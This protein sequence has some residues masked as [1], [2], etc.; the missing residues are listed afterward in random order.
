MTT[1]AGTDL[2]SGFL[3]K[4]VKL[5]PKITGVAMSFCTAFGILL[6]TVSIGVSQY[7]F[8]KTMF[9]TALITVCYAIIAI[10]LFIALK[11]RYRIPLQD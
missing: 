9:P 2:M 5:Y 7:F 6:N 10:A 8:D 11:Y 1:S 4:A 3:L